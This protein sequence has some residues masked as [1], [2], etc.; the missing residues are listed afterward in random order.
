MKKNNIMKIIMPIIF[1]VIFVMSS[2]TTASLKGTTVPDLDKVITTSAIY[3]SNY[4]VEGIDLYP[5]RGKAVGVNTA[6]IGGETELPFDLTTYSNLQAFTLI[7]ANQ[8]AW[9][10]YSMRRFWDVPDGVAMMLVFRQQTA[11]KS[12]EEGKEIKAMMEEIYGV[13]LN[14]IYGQ[15]LSEGSITQLVYYGNFVGTSDISDFIG[16][17]T[18]YTPNDGFGAGITYDLL[19]DA[20]VKSMAISVI[21]GRFPFLGSLTPDWIPVLE[22]S[23]IDPDGLNR[24]DSII[25]M[26]LIDIM[27]D[28]GTVSGAS[29]SNASFVTMELP[30]IVDILE[31]DPPT[32]NMYPHLNRKFEWV[33]EFNVNFL[34]LNISRE[35]ADI[36][37]KYDLNLTNLQNFP[38]VIGEMSLK[39][40]LPIT[41]GE[42]IQYSFTW[43]NVGNEDAYNISLAY[44]EFGNEMINGLNLPVLNPDLAF[45]QLQVMYYNMTSGLFT[46]TPLLPGPDVISLQGWFF[47]ANTSDWFYNNQIIPDADFDLIFELIYEEETFLE[48]DQGDFDLVN[49]TN[50]WTLEA[51]IDSLAPGENVTKEF[52]IKNIPTGSYTFYNEPVETAPGTYL[53]TPNITIDWE[54]YITI[55]LRIFGSTLHIPEDQVR[56]TNLFPEPVTGSSF[57]YEDATEKQ[58]MGITNGLIYQVYDNEAVVIGKLSL[59]P[60]ELGNKVYRFDD[61]V[62]YTLELTNIGD[63]DAID[64]NYVL[65][66]AFVSDT[67]EVQYFHPIIGTNGTYPVIH[68]GETVQINLTSS[69]RTSIGI[70]PV[71]AVFGYTSDEPEIDPRD[72]PANIPAR[73]MEELLK[74]FENNTGLLLLALY[75]AYNEPIFSTVE[76]STVFS[77][78]DFGIVIP[79]LNKEGRLEPTYPTPEVEVVTE[80]IYD[81][82]LSQGDE[83]VL[84]SS[85]TNVGDEPTNIIFIQRIPSE[86]TPLDDTLSVTIEGIPYYDYDDAWLPPTILNMGVGVVCDTVN[87]PRDYE[88]FELGVN[89]TVVVEV[90]LRVNT[91]NAAD[92]FI[93]PTEIRYRSEFDMAETNGIN[94]DVDTPETDTAS[95]GQEMI[96]STS[97]D[98]IDKTFNSNAITLPTD[99]AST[100]SWGAYANSLSLVLEGLAGFNINF[101]YIGVGLIAVTGVA[102]LIYFRANGKK[103]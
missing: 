45:N 2:F 6:M 31:I 12:V 20:P 52:T 103:H 34:N 48:L 27:P 101:I 43:E 58:Y 68:P 57:Y 9:Q 22:C 13:R 98:L 33:L 38:Q 25:D 79:P 40:T 63:S 39:N 92:V 4:Y 84:R 62:N 60:N 89:E 81:G 59:V 87:G 23:W 54:E 86:L 8:R 15:W 66:H 88:G 14:L 96:S 10:L 1:I 90:T 30:Y 24:V 19:N 75:N 94:E 95:L 100:N 5:L 69:A 51:T 28:L 49:Y 76:H 11:D 74:A 17:F 102:V 83:I 37:V 18:T 41:G 35:Y 36:H 42:D 55:F 61:T 99:G 50:V 80:L 82:N 7:A 91:R 65:W 47:D 26:N 85:V 46:S 32:D 3:D 29:Y 16:N 53:M 71:F 56:L 77:S 64:I 72:D 21:Q 73:L 93:P 70:H 67:H 97:A 44:G 78:M